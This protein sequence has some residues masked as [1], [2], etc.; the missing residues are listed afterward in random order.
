MVEWIRNEALAKI[1]RDRVREAGGVKKLAK[2]LGYGPSMI[3]MTIHGHYTVSM[4]LARKLGYAC[5]RKTFVRK[6]GEKDWKPKENVRLALKELVDQVGRKEAAKKLGIDEH[7][8]YE[9]LNF[10][11][12]APG[13]GLAMKLGL[14]VTH[15]CVFAKFDDLWKEAA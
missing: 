8:L 10:I 4:P 1:L 13:A 6:E 15:V 11:K 3:S 2:E 12:P 5:R 14:Q 9:I 7:Y